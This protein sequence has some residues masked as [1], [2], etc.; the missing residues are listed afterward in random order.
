M[1]FYH[2]LVSNY[3]TNEGFS[4]NWRENGFVLIFPFEVQIPS[5]FLIFYL[6]FVVVI[7][8]VVLLTR[9]K[10]KYIIETKIFLFNTRMILR[11]Q[12]CLR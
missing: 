5:L 9:R 2:Y 12:L 7:A 10:M 8:V 3:S 11:Y 1:S 4:R 6:P